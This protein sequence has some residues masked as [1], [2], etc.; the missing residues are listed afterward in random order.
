MYTFG[1]VGSRARHPQH[2]L[3]VLLTRRFQGSLTLFYRPEYPNCQG[4]NI[5]EF[6]FH[7][8]VFLLHHEGLAQS[9]ATLVGLCHVASLPIMSGF[10]VAGVVLGSIPL[11]IS[12]L[13][14]YADG[15]MI[16]VSETTIAN[17]QP[18]FQPSGACESTKM[19]SD[20]CMHPSLQLLVYTETHARTFCAHWHYQI[21]NCIS[22]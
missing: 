2:C 14:H 10:E 6:S 1:V 18:S 8:R 16:P 17:Y 3:I 21:F 9:K 12:A 13:E 5:L 15:V 7:L 22:C 20:I 4:H 11:I 19:S